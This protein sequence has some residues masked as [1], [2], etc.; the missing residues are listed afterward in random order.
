[1]SGSVSAT[2]PRK[3]LVPIV[4]AGGLLA[5]GVLAASTTGTLGGFVATITNGTNTAASGV[6][7]MRA[8]SSD[9]TVTCDSTDGGGVSVNSA[10]C[11]TLDEFGGSTTLIPGQ[12]LKTTVAITNSGSVTAQAFS[13]TAG[14]CAQSNNGAVNGSATDMCGMGLKIVSGGT[15]L[16]DGTLAGFKASPV[17]LSALAAGSSQS[18]DFTVTIPSSAGNGYQGLKASLPLTWTFNS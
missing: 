4:L 12:S 9:G 7:T 3:K 5:A 11:S 8:A 17:N 16:Y 10:T 6:L 18:F 2:L 13:L 14:D 1:M 15:T